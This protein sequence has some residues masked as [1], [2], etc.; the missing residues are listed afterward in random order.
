ME[1]ISVKTIKRLEFVDITRSV[2]D[3]VDKKK[4]SSGIVYL[5]VPHTTAGIT[6]NENADPSVKKDLIDSL[7]RLLPQTAKYS[8]A[9]GN[10]DAHVKSTLM[11]Q[12]LNL[13]VENGK[14]A[15]GTWQGIY[16]CEGDGPRA[17]EVWVKIIENK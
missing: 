10:S 17:R 16:F 14:L 7:T 11:G 15:L 4:I 8:H 1:K 9:E 6:I 13:F 2:Q 12:S 3:I 5:F